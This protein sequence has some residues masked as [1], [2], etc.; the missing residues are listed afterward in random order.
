MK[1]IMLYLEIRLTAMDITARNYRKKPVGE[2]T[3]RE[4][5]WQILA[6]GE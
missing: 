4:C 5:I 6:D 3:E 1:V 2:I